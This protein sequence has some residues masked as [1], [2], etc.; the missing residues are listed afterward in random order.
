MSAP[1]K[2]MKSSIPQGLLASLTGKWSILVLLLVLL[3]SGAWAREYMRLAPRWGAGAGCYQKHSAAEA[4]SVGTLKIC[5]LD[6]GCVLFELF[7]PGTEIFEPQRIIGTLILDDEENGIWCSPTNEADMLYFSKYNSH[8]T[9]RCA[10][11]FLPQAA[12]SYEFSAPLYAGIDMVRAFV[13]YLPSAQTF[14]Q[15]G[16]EYRTE[17]L[18]SGSDI[19]YRKIKFVDAAGQVAGIFW[20]TP[21]L[22]KVYRFVG[23]KGYAIFN[24]QE[25]KQAQSKHSKPVR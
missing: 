4:Q 11:G 18:L 17:E 5:P 20:V 12:G 13:E 1:I 21:S 6:E 23:T 9:V 19:E 22:D 2:S 24:R 16:A 10:A 15:P 3:C 8:I 25:Q 7:C 14:L